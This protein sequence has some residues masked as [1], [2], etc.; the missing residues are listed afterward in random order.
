MQLLKKF[1]VATI[2]SVLATGIVQS[3][4]EPA[5]EDW[6]NAGRQ[7]V[8][9]A[10]HLNPNEKHAKNIILFV[11]DGMGVSTVTAARI[12]DGQQKGGHGEENSLSFEKLPYLALS[13]T[14]S[15]DQQT[16]DSAPTM[17]A[18]VTGVKTIGDSLSVNQFV[19]HSEPDANIVNANKL[20]TIL[21]RAKSD[22]MSVGIV[23]TARITHATPAAT[24]AHT[25][26]RDW[27]G[28]SDLPAGATVP[29]IAAQ[30]IDFNINGGIDVALGGGRTR[31][32]PKTATDPEYGIAGKRKDGR[33]LTADWINKH[34]NARY[35]W[36]KEQFDAIDPN[37]TDHLLGLFEPSHVHY[38]ADRIAHDKAGE[39]SLTEM[40]RKA[41]DILKKNKN[42]YFLMV[43]GGRIDHAHHSGNAYRALTDTQQL[44]AAVQAAMEKT[45]TKETLIIVTA[46]HSH[47]FT[48]GGYPQRG[49][50]ILGLTQ[51]V[52]ASSPDL[53]MLGLP[54]TTLNYANGTGYT[55]A[56]NLQPAGSKTFTTPNTASWP[57]GSEGHNPASFSPAFGRPL[58]VN[59]QVQAPD[60]LQE[61]IIP[62][63][64]ETHAAEDVAIFAGGPK[65]HLFH[66]VMEQNV[67]YHVMAEALGLAEQRR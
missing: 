5:P 31:F 53:D 8:I 3:A 14:Y 27:E 55:G 1:S 40:T 59:P 42:G 43:E 46:D 23:S 10:G 51:G 25:T 33:D 41:I 54:Y 60:Y 4:E 26:N 21:E 2:S 39:P 45:N 6:F 22:G 62:L 50:P 32:I 36:N 38:E 24:Y 61:T 34:N 12:Y 28:D 44:A 17:T 20:T 64:A 13:K 15:V 30:L 67:I 49:N 48:I 9:D 52:G 66:G 18:M 65:A 47:V 58:L 29:D 35:V 57:S 16:P 11:G 63:G 7:T 19:A 37:A 56:S